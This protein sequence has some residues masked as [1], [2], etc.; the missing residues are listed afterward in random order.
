MIHIRNAWGAL[1]EYIVIS[2]SIS[3]LER[4]CVCWGGGGRVGVMVWEGW[5]IC[6]YYEY[7]YYGENSQVTNTPMAF[8]GRF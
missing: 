1:P 2:P 4:V 6:I 5:W 8:D 3:E 7:V